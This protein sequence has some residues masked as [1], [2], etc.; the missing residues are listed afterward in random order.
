MLPMAARLSS[1]SW[2]Q[3]DGAALEAIL[4]EVTDVGIPRI[5]EALGLFE[6]VLNGGSLDETA[7]ALEPS[8]PVL[9]DAM[10]CILSHKWL[11]PSVMKKTP[12]GKAVASFFT[13][14]FGAGQVLS[15]FSST[16]SFEKLKAQVENVSGPL[17]SVSLTFGQIVMT[18]LPNMT[19]EAIERHKA[20]AVHAVRALALDPSMPFR[21]GNAPSQED[22]TQLVNDRIVVFSDLMFP[23]LRSFCYCYQLAG[24]VLQLQTNLA[25]S[26]SVVGAKQWNDV[27]CKQSLNALMVGEKVFASEAGMLLF[28]YP[29]DA[30]KVLTHHRK[31]GTIPS[32]SGEVTPVDPQ[33][34]LHM[35]QWQTQNG[36]TVIVATALEGD[37]DLS[38]HG[39]LISPKIFFESIEPSMQIS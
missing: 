5:T 32:D 33:K 9:T 28:C 1:S 20:P 23:L 37:G 35:I 27:L 17:S 16:D 7:V 25:S 11:V 12:D 36:N 3:K 30:S 29:G 31:R 19:L 13:Q 6:Q 2:G 18:H 34:V 26:L 15:L 39:L 24:Y 22:G 21:E 4:S 8:D 10:R 38:L 14:A